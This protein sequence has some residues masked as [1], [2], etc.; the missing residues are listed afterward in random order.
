MRTDREGSGRGAKQRKLAS[1][2]A[3]C[4]L[5]ASRGLRK[6]GHTLRTHMLRGVLICVGTA[7]AAAAALLPPTA[8]QAASRNWHGCNRAATTFAANLAG[9]PAALDANPALRRVFGDQLPSA[10]FSA[11]SR[12]YC[13]DFD[14]DGDVDRAAQYVCCTVSSPSPFVVLRNTGASLRS[15]TSG[16]A[17]PSFASAAPAASSSCASPS[18]RAMTPTAAPRAT[19]T[20]R[21]AGRARASRPPRGSDA[22]RASAE[23]AVLRLAFVGSAHFVVAARSSVVRVR[24]AV[25]R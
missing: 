6:Q 21:C 18:T 20:A 16:S 14:G 22:L 13:A 7:V 1:R 8:A 4:L 3:G 11:V 17:L 2:R 23:R 25:V 24:P 15:S 5:G 19:A 12:A 10:T 9:V